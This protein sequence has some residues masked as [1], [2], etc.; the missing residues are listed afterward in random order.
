MALS[1]FRQMVYRIYRNPFVMF[2]LGPIYIFLIEYRFNR[3]SASQKECLNT[4]ITNLGL[5]GI[6][7]L[8]CWTMDRHEFLLVQGPI[9]YF[10]GIIGIWLFYVQHQFE[11]TYFEKEDN[12]NFVSA[13]LQG[14]SHYKL[15]K[16]LQWI[17]GNIGFHHIHHLASR[18][19]N[20]NLQ[21]VYE[22]NHSFRN[23][24][25]IGLLSSLRS[26]HYR[27]WDEDSKKFVGFRDITGLKSMR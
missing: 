17:T 13:A 2:G 12:W 22:S 7:G 23:V 10:S 8:L 6:V 26:L 18:V 19:P 14:S 16:I 1:T 25:A 24:P 15:P 11:G 21:R 9:L 5:I 27:V 20:Y 4:H 3:K